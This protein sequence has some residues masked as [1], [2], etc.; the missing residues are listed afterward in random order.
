M[1]GSVIAQILAVLLIPII[2][3]LYTPEDYGLFSLILAITAIIAIFSSLSYQ[4]AIM[5]PKEDE[6]A[7]HI[8]AL[9]GILILFSSIL[10]GVICIFFADTLAN[11]LNVPALT[12][13]LWCVPFLVFFTAIFSVLSYWNSR[14]K[15]FGVYA[16]AQVTNSLSGKSVQIGTGISYASPFGLILGSI[17]GFFCAILVMMKGFRGD[18]EFFKNTTKRRMK[19]LAIRYKKFPLLNSFSTTANTVSTQITPIIFTF[20]FN[21]TIVGYYAIALQV[22]SMPMQ[23]IGNAIGQVFFQRASE[24]NNR[25]GNIKNIV[26]ELHQRL[27]RIGVFPTLL[28]MVLGPQLFSFVFGKAWGDAGV[29]A[30]ILAPW[31]LLV[32]ITSPLSTLFTVFER[33]GINLAINT[34]VL[35]SRILVLFIGGCIGDPIITLVLFSLTGVLFVGGSNYYILRMAGVNILKEIKM[36]IF[37]LFKAVLMVIPLIIAK[38]I[39][40]PTYAMFGIAGLLLILFY[41]LVIRED[42]I[43]QNLLFSIVGKR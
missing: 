32:F 29:Y 18:L 10:T 24:E 20:F 31:F 5:L 28:L 1:S 4:L 3:R 41:Y 21:P 8:V 42:P 9:C 34:L 11:A 35:L 43:L 30:A 12:H 16:I 36:N 33:L 6:D 2:T 23:L 37:I 27:L 40:V 14:R 26:T 19:E 7:A 25:T 15:R 38:Y 39:N 13:Y 22:V 17:V